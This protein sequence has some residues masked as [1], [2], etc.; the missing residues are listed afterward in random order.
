MP[1]PHAHAPLYVLN[2]PLA[3]D[4]DA[5]L[6]RRGAAPPPR[7]TPAD[8]AHARAVFTLMDA[9]GSGSVDGRELGE[10]LEVKECGER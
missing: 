4:V 7:L 3:A 10:A 2:P 8:A 9:D 6:A 1:T 5:W